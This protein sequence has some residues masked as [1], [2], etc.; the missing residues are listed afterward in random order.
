MEDQPEQ[1]VCL[2]DRDGNALLVAVQD[3]DVG[4]SKAPIENNPQADKFDRPFEP[5]LQAPDYQD[6]CA[7]GGDAELDIK[8]FERDEEESPGLVE[9]APELFVGCDCIL[10]GLTESSKNGH[11]CVVFKLPRDDGRCVVQLS[12][13]TQSKLSV[14]PS[15][16]RP[17]Q[18]P[19]ES[20]Q[21]YCARILG[22]TLRSLGV[23]ASAEAQ[24]CL[25]RVRPREILAAALRAAQRDLPDAPDALVEAQQAHDKLM[26]LDAV[27]GDKAAPAQLLPPHALVEC[28]LLG[29][30]AAHAAM[31]AASQQ[32]I[33]TVEAGI[34]GLRQVLG[35]EHRRLARESGLPWPLP[36]ACRSPAEGPD[37][38][39]LRL[40]LVRAL[41]R[42]RQEEQAAL[43]A[44]ACVRR[45]PQDAASLLWAGRCLLRIG[46]CEQG[47]KY[48]A[49]AE[50]CPGPAAEGAWGHQGATMRLQALSQVERLKQA[51]ED[52]YAYGDFQTAAARYGEAVVHSPTDDKWG[53]ATLHAAR[54]A[55]HRR[56][57]DFR[58]AVDDCDAALALFPNYARA[59]FRRA[60]CLIEAGRPEEAIKSLEVLL[61]VDRAWPNLCDWLVRAHALARRLDSKDSFK[62]S[63]KRGRRSREAAEDAATP[64]V[65]DLYSVLGVSADATDQ[66]LKR[67]YRLMSLKYHPDKQGGSTR[68]FQRIAMAYETLSD[69]ARRH[70]YNEGADLKKQDD[71]S[72]ESERDEKPLRE[73]V[74]RTLSRHSGCISFVWDGRSQA[75]AYA[76]SGFVPAPLMCHRKYFP[77]RFKPGAQS[78]QPR[79]Q[80]FS[81]SST[82]AYEVLAFR[83][84]LHREA[85]AV[86]ATEAG[87]RAEAL[88]C[89]IV[90]D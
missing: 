11:P 64:E 29:G 43:E 82:S 52:A 50:R 12:G 17:L 9:E 2:Q 59:L 37:A 49:M 13:G 23:G 34:A 51:A 18:R 10:Q 56:A 76:V 66:Q 22:L 88:D 44:E 41:L 89:R 48:L 38:L 45:H 62:S 80:G 77:E 4:S 35:D 26:L 72:D 86:G 53:R 36:A 58:Q 19:N 68:D 90:D 1:W 5:R 28:G 21:S 70:A 79:K 69:P 46:R 87:C 24:G 39:R 63:W 84:S 30:R 6:T 55:C 85:Q 78:E 16:L 25:H 7:E 57:R 32:S 14:K 54:A 31:N 15:N 42:S 65:S 3:S 67:A 40:T 75:K 60:A 20:E 73:E 81:R 71:D 61:R 74:E 83:R 47:K 8:T 33:K 27:Q